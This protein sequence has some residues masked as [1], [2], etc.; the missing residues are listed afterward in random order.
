[1]I[2]DYTAP[3]VCMLL[4]VSSASYKQLSQITIKSLGALRQTCCVCVCVVPPLRLLVSASDRSGGGLQWYWSMFTGSHAGNHRSESK[5]V[6]QQVGVFFFSAPVGQSGS[7]QVE[8]G[9][10]IKVYNLWPQLRL[11]LDRPKEGHIEARWKGAMVTVRA[12]ELRCIHLWDSNRGFFMFV[13]HFSCL[14]VSI[15]NDPRGWRAHISATLM[16]WNISYSCTWILCH[17][18]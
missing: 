13:I 2:N 18:S 14:T 12:P 15:L 11:P 5:Q 6:S 10:W 16:A 9:G 3:L 7:G 8:E 17:Y 4:L 1:M